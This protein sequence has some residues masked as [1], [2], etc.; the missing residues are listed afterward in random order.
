MRVVKFFTKKILNDT[1]KPYVWYIEDSLKYSEIVNK[2]EDF[3]RQ[4]QLICYLSS[5]LIFDSVKEY[6]ET[7]KKEI[8][9]NKDKTFNF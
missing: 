9:I 7:V 5:F 1:I 6:E 4:E 8:Q 3:L 2:I